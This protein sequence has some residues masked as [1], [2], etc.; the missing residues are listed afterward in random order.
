MVQSVAYLYVPGWW[1]GDVYVDGYWRPSARPDGDWVWVDGY[2]LDDGGYLPGHWRPAG[3]GP[4]GYVWEAGFFDGETWVDGFWRPEYFAGYVWVSAWFDEDGVY[5]SGYWE[6]TDERP[7]QVWV[8]GWF[9]GTQW[10]R[11]YW[12]GQAEYEAADPVGYQPEVGWNDGWDQAE[13]APADEPALPLALPVVT[14][15]LSS[16]E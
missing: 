3:Y 5:H 16:G 9:D 8:P 6:P 4:E 15:G 13:P 12:V 10:V 14:D 7:G 11:G 1:Q 2:Y